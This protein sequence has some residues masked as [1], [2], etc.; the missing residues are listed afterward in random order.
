MKDVVVVGASLAG[1]STAIQLA[2]MGLSVSL[3]DRAHFPRRKACGEGLFPRGVEALSSLGVYQQVRG[4]ARTLDSLRVELDGAAVEAPLASPAYPAI[5]VRRELLDAA[6]LKCAEL[7]SVEVCQGVTVLDVL[8]SPSG[9][10]GVRTDHGDFEARVIVAADGLRSRLRRIAG[11]DAPVR[12]QRYGVSAHYSLHEEVAARVRIRMLDGY[13]AYLTPVA[14]RMVNVALLMGRDRS[15]VLA[16]RLEES[17][18]A[19][20]RASGILAEGATL[21]DAPLTGGPFPAGARRA[22]R[23]NLLLAGDAAG[24]LD[25]ISGEGMSIA[26][27]A[28]QFAADAVRGFIDTANDAHLRGYERRRRS[29]VRNSNLMSRISLFVAGHRRIGRRAIGNLSKRP[30]TFEKFLSINSGVSGLRTL[31]PRD[32]ACLLFGV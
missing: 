19:L 32:A 26:L 27:V 4:G 23:D 30:A 31:T 7:D 16:G 14:E 20:V 25:G 22:W 17:F 28:S 24:F 6:L 15:A 12:S 10:R 1:A 8:T 9:Y 18:D 3:I 29:L 21:L 5:G 11:L 13:E 2:R